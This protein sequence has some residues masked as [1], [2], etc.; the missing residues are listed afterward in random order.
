MLTHRKIIGLGVFTFTLVFAACETDSQDELGE[1]E[2]DE[3]GMTIEGE[4]VPADACEFHDGWE[5]NFS[6]EKPSMV[7]WQSFDEWTAYHRIDDA[8]LCAG[9]DDW[10]HVDVESLGYAEHYLYIRAL[11]KDAGLCGAD[12]G[13]PVIPAG[14]RHAMTVEVYRADTMELLTTRTQDDGVLSINGPG[15]DPYA[16]ALL[17][18]VFSP[19]VDAAYPY[20]LSIEVRNYDGEDECEC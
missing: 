10:Y 4:I 6:P 19:T 2:S 17:I 3:S 5:P 18:H 1:G 15:G 14:P 16:H 9:E 20:R 13:S 11:I 8:G 7:P 12:C